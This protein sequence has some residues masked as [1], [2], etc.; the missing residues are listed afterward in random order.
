MADGSPLAAKFTD[1]HTTAKGEDRAWVGLRRLETLWLNT[2]T[3]CNIACENCY[4]ESTPRNDALVYLTLEE[5]L[6]YLGEAEGMGTR[7]V[8]ITGG[9]PFMNPDAVGIVAAALSRGFVVLVLTNAMRPMMRPRVLEELLS[10]PERDRSRLTLR[11]SLDHFTRELHDAERGEGSFARAMDGIDWLAEH[12]F[13]LAVAGRT[14][15]GEGEEASR[16]GYAAMLAGRGIPIDASDPKALVLFPEMRAKDDPPEITTACWGILGKSPDSV[17]CSSSRMVVKRKG[18]DAP[19]VLSCTLLAYD[20]RF[21]MGGTLEEASRPVPLNH[22]W[23]AT[24]CVLGGA[25][26]S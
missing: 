7:E 2:G 22:P 18:A 14:M 10:I 16:A 1:P 6:P 11:V 20:E 19:A 4:I 9:E 8:G 15:H 5:A 23:C 13:R 21:E 12:G 25:S 26:C 3:L 24:F 17:M